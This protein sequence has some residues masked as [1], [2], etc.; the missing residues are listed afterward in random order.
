MILV[1]TN[2]TSGGRSGKRKLVKRKQGDSIEQKD[3]D[4][5]DL[6]ILNNVP[7]KKNK[8]NEKVIQE[9]NQSRM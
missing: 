5:E 4:D 8:F 2:W 1:S 6:Q 7:L 3:E 9:D